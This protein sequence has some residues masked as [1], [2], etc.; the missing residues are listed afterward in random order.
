MSYSFQIL[1]RNA[2]LQEEKASRFWDHMIMSVCLCMQLFL[3]SIVKGRSFNFNLICGLFGLYCPT[4]EFFTHMET[5][6]ANFDLCSAFMAF[7]QWGFFSLPHLLRHGASFYNGHL[8]AP[9]TLPPIA[10]C[11]AVEL[12][13]PIFTTYVCRG[14]DSNTQPLASGAKYVLILCALILKG[15][16]C[17]YKN[18]KCYMHL[19]NL[20]KSKCIIPNVRN[21]D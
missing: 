2:S 19:K 21:L 15:F 20:F 18:A 4:R 11:L 10:K 5:S 16:Y 17:F 3:F 8:W 1:Y 7:E 14:W 6:T 12:S 13:L 9:V